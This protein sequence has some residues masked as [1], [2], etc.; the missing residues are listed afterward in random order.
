MTTIAQRIKFCRLQRGFSQKE[1]AEKL[2]I[3]Q[4]AYAKIEN[5]I[6][7]LDVDRLLDICSLL[8]IDIKQLI[9][10]LESHS[11]EVETEGDLNLPQD[12]LVREAYAETIRNLK[13]EIGFLRKLLM[14]EKDH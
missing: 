3:S 12:A 9:D 14:K 7:K 10:Q 8:T 5:G 11:P 1:M 13:E 2:L 4:S 6:T